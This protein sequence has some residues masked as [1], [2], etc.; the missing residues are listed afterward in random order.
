MN[1]LPPYSELKRCL[2]FY[3]ED[4]AVHSSEKVDKYRAD[5]T[6]SH[7]RRL[8]I[9]LVVTSMRSSIKGFIST[10]IY[11]AFILISWSCRP[12]TGWLG[13][14]VSAQATAS[15]VKVEDGGGVCMVLLNLIHTRLHDVI[16]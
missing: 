12:V 8:A 5:C 14:S 6:L 9:L 3:P 11:I 1:I 4:N 16:T 7:P 2:T 15:V 13:T 10:V